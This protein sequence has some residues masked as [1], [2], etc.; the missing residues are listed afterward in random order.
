MHD[1]R[2]IH[3]QAAY[4]K[5]HLGK[6]I[7]FKKASTIALAIYIDVDFARSPLVR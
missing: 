3:L 5:A 2:E 1:L 6:G 4:L 7:L